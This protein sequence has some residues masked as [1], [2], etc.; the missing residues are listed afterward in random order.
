MLISDLS[1]KRTEIMCQNLFTRRIVQNFA[2][3]ATL[4]SFFPTITSK[5]VSQLS[6][7]TLS[8]SVFDFLD[9]NDSLLELWGLLFMK[10]R[11]S[12]D[13]HRFCK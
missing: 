3:I 11:K 1:E 4:L 2:E 9:F 10:F 6:E 5:Y 12:F 7:K 13:K 8:L